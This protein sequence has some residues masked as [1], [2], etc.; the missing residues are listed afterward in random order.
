[1]NITSE[2]QESLNLI[3][4]K[5]RLKLILLHGSYVTARQHPGSDLDIA[6]LGPK[7]LSFEEEM[8]IYG[9]LAKIF[10]DDKKREL[11]VKSLHGTDPLF[12]YEVARDS[13]LLYGSRN[14]YDQFRCTAFVAY[15][16]SRDLRQLERLLNQRQL[17]KL[18]KAY[19]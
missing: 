19:A 12:L 15:M 9:E 10:G 8:E 16:D 3:G 6:L 7:R 13:Q 1:M 18:K 17:K 5:H 2:Q 14:D 4:Q 11:D